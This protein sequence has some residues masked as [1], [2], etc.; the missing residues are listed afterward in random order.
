MS[1]DK[2]VNLPVVQCCACGLILLFSAKW[3]L[4]PSGIYC[5][6]CAPVGGKVFSG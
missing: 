2:V 4:H 5:L 1:K 3:V 6:G